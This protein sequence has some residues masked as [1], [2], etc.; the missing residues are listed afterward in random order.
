MSLFIAHWIEARITFS[1][2]TLSAARSGPA[3]TVAH[4]PSDRINTRARLRATAAEH[5]PESTDASLGFAVFVGRLYRAL[6]TTGHPALILPNR[7]RSAQ[8]DSS[9]GPQNNPARLP[10]A[11]IVLNLDP[12]G[13]ASPAVA[14]PGE[15][16][17]RRNPPAVRSGAVPGCAVDSRAQIHIDQSGHGPA[18]GVVDLEGQMVG[19]IGEVSKVDALAG[20][21]SAGLVKEASSRPTWRSAQSESMTWAQSTPYIASPVTSCPARASGTVSP[22]RPARPN[23]VTRGLMSK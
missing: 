8:T 5:L 12:A 14:H 15:V 17:A 9:P 11:A 10:A 22:T 13:I 3:F 2:S 19:N 7:C 18:P 1:T 21:L 23:A 4:T 6:P 20:L 16:G